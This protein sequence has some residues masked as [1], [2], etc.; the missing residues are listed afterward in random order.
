MLVLSLLLLQSTVF[1]QTTT[2]TITGTVLDTTAAVIPNANVVLT[3]AGTKDVRRTV[4][5]GEGYFTFAA[6]QPGTYN[7]KVDIKGFKSWA[8]SGVVVN[9]GDKRNISNIKLDVGSTEQIVTVEASASQVA[10]LDSGER[11]ALLSSKDI[12]NLSLVGRD[13]TELLRILP[14]INTFSPDGGV[15]NKAGYDTTIVGIGSGVGRGYNANGN[16]FRGGTDLVSDGAHV[17]DPG[18]NCNATQTI[19]A[20]MVQEV[21]VQTSNFG[22]DSVKGP[23]VISAVGKSGSQNYHGEG[24]LY[25]RNSIF[26]ANDWLYNNSKTPRPDERYYYPGGSFGGPVKIPGTNFNHDKKLTFWTGYE[27]YNQMYPFSGGLLQTRVPTASMRN[28]NF[29]LTAVDNAAFCGANAGISSCITPYN[30]VPTTVDSNGAGTSWT[31]FANSQIPTIDPGGAAI[32]KMFPDANVDPASNSGYNY[33]KGLTQTKNGFMYKG[34]VDYSFSE[35][36]KLYVSYNLQKE[37]GQDPVM[38]WWTPWMAADYP[39]NVL[40]Q[41]TSHTISA[42]FV[43]I[44]TPTFTNEAV[45]SLGYGNFPYTLSNPSAVSKEALGYPYKGVYKNGYDQMPAVWDWNN[46]GYPQLGMYGFLNGVLSSTKM[47]PSFSDNITKVWRTHTFKAGMYWEKTGN[48]QINPGAYPQGQYSFVSDWS[49]FW[50]TYGNHG[51]GNSVANLLMGYAQ[52]YSETNYVP[53]NDMA[54]TT[55]GFFLNDDWKV[56]KKLTLQ[57]GLRFDHMGTWYDKSGTGLAVWEPGKFATDLAAGKYEPG[58]YWTKTDSSLPTSGRTVAPIFVSP[59]FGLAYDVF[60][61]SKTVLRGGFGAYRWRDQYN[62]FAGA[63]ATSLGQTTTDLGSIQMSQIDS[64]SAPTL[65][66]KA[67]GIWAVNANDHAQPVTYSYNFTI[68]QAMPFNSVLEVAYVGNQSH[69]LD[70]SGVDSGSN[71]NQ[72]GN[73]N[74]VPLG[75]FFSPDPVTGTQRNPSDAGNN[76]KDDYRPYCGPVG[77]QCM[78]YG[79]LLVVNHNG[80]ANYNALQVSWNRMRGWLTYGANYTWSKALGINT[81]ADP[82]NLNNDYGVLNSDRSHVFNANY[83]IDLGTRFHGDNPLVRGLANGWQFSGITTIQSG[84]NLQAASPTGFNLSFNPKDMNGNTLSNNTQL[85]TSDYIFMPTV[86]CNPAA[87]V[88]GNRYVNGA[89]FSVNTAVGQNGNYQMPYLHGPAY[90]SND[91]TLLKNF[92]LTERQNLQFRVAG[93]NVFNHPLSSLNNSDALHLNMT[94]SSSGAWTVTHSNQPFGSAPIK[95]GRRVVELALKYSF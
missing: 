71:G 68:S 16:P 81:D 44:F 10:V 53:T 39:G 83:Q 17:L 60:G 15:D 2:G 75:A 89:C 21:K 61:N 45:F 63:L 92:K 52:D 35:S 14:G 43:K 26:N 31:P 77:G 30:P 19:N 37:T 57:I 20:D 1:A 49:Y 82:L 22:A 7:V 51:T 4:S 95:Y 64:H 66:G 27:Y 34:R 76:F 11:S 65:S 84:P 50:N 47:M 87:G 36:T 23:V 62:T 3:N 91:V 78:G 48:K 8:I 79:R 85:G 90:L 54:Y 56:S 40:E 55:V 73:V 41:N 24:Y 42:N 86:T 59:R 13:A 46:A 74:L 9:V 93:F 6:V 88:A 94:Q 29:S 33:V 18:C 28:G 5:N 58:L 25:A 70:T 80:F 72:L 12:Q 67:N 38:I 69:F 32:M